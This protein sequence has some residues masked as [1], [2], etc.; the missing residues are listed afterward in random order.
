MT[1]TIETNNKR[2]F[3]SADWICIG[4]Y[5]ILLV[6]GWFSVCGASYDFT[7]PNVFGWESNSGKQM[8]WILT[9]FILAGAL[10]LIEKRFY[11]D[12]SKTL[13][14][15]M[16]I[17]L[18]ITIFIA[19]DTKGSRSFI[20]IGP[21]KLQPAELAKFTVALA[22]ARVMDRY[23]FNLRLRRDFIQVM[24]IIFLP[25]V[26]I[27]AEKET[28]SAL[29]YLALFL[30]LFREGM[31]GSVLFAV[32]A[33]VVYFVVGL[34]FGQEQIHN[35]PASVGEF[36][37]LLLAYLFTLGMTAVYQKDMRV[38]R[39]LLFYGGGI[40]LA[41]WLFS[42]YV[43]PFNVCII[44]LI[45]CILMI[46]YLAYIAV[47][48]RYNRYAFITI[49]AIISTVTYYIC[50]Y[51]FN[52]ILQDHQRTRIEVLLGTKDDPRGAGYNVNQAKIAIGSGGFSGKG[53]LNGTQTKLKYVPEQ[54][55]DFI[56]CTVG[57]ED[58][59]VG[60]FLVLLLYLCLI[61]RIF[62][63]AERQP[64]TLGRVYGYSVGCIFLFH[65]FINVGMVLGM[66]PVIGIPLPFF[67]YGG[68]SLWGFTILLFIF[69]RMDAEHKA[70]ITGS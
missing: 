15:V 69:L 22:L 68:S 35:M 17:L 31:T 18:F 5:F 53:F 24:C 19:P 37:V 55:T 59:F 50:G 51:V 9:S 39:V 28:G 67:S 70:K 8:I 48:T 38:V 56:F 16:M 11:C 45:V 61:I 12:I 3:R 29:V 60:S 20:P 23:G 4:L 36:W 44:Q 66:T 1:E 40:Q 25:V 41:A 49:F 54:D 34:K 47:T 27:L 26:L 13:Y 10:L 58:G 43:I 57:E 32:F 6:W 63:L 7:N 21:V 33:C 42:V 64:D 30:V 46:L 52:H 14:I 2:V 65:L 62:I